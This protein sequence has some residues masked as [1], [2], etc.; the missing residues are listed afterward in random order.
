MYEELTSMHFFRFVIIDCL[1]CNDEEHE[2][3]E[4]K[5]KTHRLSDV[6]VYEIE[7]QE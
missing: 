3:R 5:E 2:N 7:Q 6:T 1:S 4:R